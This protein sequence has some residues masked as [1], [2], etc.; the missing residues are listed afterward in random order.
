MKKVIVGPLK[1]TG[2]STLIIIDAL[3]ECRDEEPASSILSIL[4]RFVD[5]IPNVKFFITGRPEPQIRSGFR[6]Q[7]LARITEVLKLHEVKPEAVNSDIE[8]FFRTQLTALVKRRSVSDLAE[9]WPSSSDMVILCEKAGGFFFYASTVVDF[10]AS[11]NHLP[12]A[13]L[14]LVTSFPHDTPEGGKYRLDQFYTSALEQAFSNVHDDQ[15]YSLF[16]TV[17]GA[18]L[19]I[20][21]PLSIEGLSTLLGHHTS[22]ILSTTRPLHSLLLVPDNLEDPVC[23]FHKSFPDF[24]TDPHRCKDG[25]FFVNPT[26]YHGEILFS[27]LNLMGER[28]KENICDLD[29]HITLGKVEDLSVRR[30]EN[31]GDALEYA[32]CFW[33]KHLLGIPGS[34]P[35]VNFEEVQRA[36]DNFF[37]RHL[38]YWI[39]V[40]ALIGNLDIGV[41]SLNDVEGWYESVSA[42]WTVHRD[43]RVHAYPDGNPSQVDERQSAFSLR[44]LQRNSRLSLPDIPFRSPTLSC[45]V[46]ASQVL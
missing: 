35:H 15:S 13:G 28:L 8:R 16:R 1:V 19:L 31:I 43:R 22:H 37:T 21:V 26:T 7:P 25:R 45:L 14:A 36:V 33:T 29:D 17:V 40:L 6:L 18:V 41:H 24:L 3:D 46:L 30:K 10:V 38:L 2:I 39:E 11:K 5:E 27:C 34:N 20:F 42:V 44:K 4:S 23:I 12:S 9:D 32:C